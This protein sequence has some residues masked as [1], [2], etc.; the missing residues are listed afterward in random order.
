LLPGTPVRGCG[1]TL[2][3]GIALRVVVDDAELTSSFPAGGTDVGR[4]CVVVT[5]ELGGQCCDL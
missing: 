3:T 4:G 5:M 2:A 1:Q